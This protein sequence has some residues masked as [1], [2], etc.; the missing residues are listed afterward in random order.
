VHDDKFIT[1]IYSLRFFIIEVWYS[2]TLKF[3]VFIEFWQPSD[4]L[5]TEEEIAKEE[6]EKLEALEVRNRCSK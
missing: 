6:K 1:V 2:V 4:R 5:K 3:Y